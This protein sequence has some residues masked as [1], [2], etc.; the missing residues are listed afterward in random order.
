LLLKK[1]EFLLSGSCDLGFLLLPPL[2]T[3]HLRLPLLHF[4]HPLPFIIL[5]VHHPFP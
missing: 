3:L 2:L 1:E 5:L 4:H